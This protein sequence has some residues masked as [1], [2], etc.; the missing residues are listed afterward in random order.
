MEHFPTLTTNRLILREIV[1]SD[2]SK[3][4]EIYS[5]KDAM[6]FF[7]ADPIEAVEEA[8][9]LI[10]I[11]A[12]WRKSSNPGIRWGIERKSDH[13]LIGTCGLFKW[14]RNWRSCSTAFELSEAAQGNGFMQEAIYSAFSWGFETMSL[15]RIEALVHPQ[16]HSSQKLLHKLGFKKEGI[17]REAG[18][19]NGK[20]HDLI[21][22]A[23]LRSE[24]GLPKET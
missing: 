18:F 6:R 17:L 8:E 23:L 9:K 22:F 4:F 7:G 1:A 20:H 12:N 16:N 13:K 19:W 24:F 10:E 11:F 14:N 2:A 5:N 3:L 21:Q 15:N